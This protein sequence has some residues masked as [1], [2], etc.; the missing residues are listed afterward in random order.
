MPDEKAPTP[1]PQ[2]LPDYD[3]PPLNELAVGVHFGPLNGWQ[4]THV[5]QFWTE[6][7]KEFPATED[8]TPIFDVTEVPGVQVLN[9]PPLR[10]TF[11]ISE[12]QNFVI[13]LQESRFLFNWR[14]KKPTDVYPRFSSF[15]DRFLRH[16]GQFS[17][18]VGRAKL[19]TLKPTRY[20]LT[21]V[22][23][24]EQSKDGVSA[25]AERYARMYNWNNLNAKFLAPPVA[26]NQ[27]WTFLMPEQLGHAQA[28]L[29]QGV[30]PDRRAVL[31][32][33][34]SCAGGATPKISLNDWFGAAHRWL[35]GA[36]KELTTDHARNEWGYKE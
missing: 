9:M 2:V 33:V 19:G 16:W 17:D 21:Y 36:F 32:L 7:A 30:L 29:G 11:M 3:K 13:Q 1:A 24:I 15:F 18:F 28:N 5:G 22:N 12:D 6:I 4:S 31:V 35:S 8:Q 27:V 25:T 10:R 26:V 20:E 14:R 34:M 23:H